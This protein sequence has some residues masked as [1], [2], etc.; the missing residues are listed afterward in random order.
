MSD[1]S[2]VPLSSQGKAE[3]VLQ[4]VE[5]MPAAKKAAYTKAQERCPQLMKTESDPLKFLR[6]DKDNY[7]KAAERLVMYWEERQALFG[8]KA[9]LPMTQTGNGALSVEDVMALHTG[10]YALL[11]KASSGEDVVFIDRN[12][13]LPTSTLEHKLRAFFYMLSYLTDGEHAQTLGCLVL[14]LLITPRT[15]KLDLA[16]IQSGIKLGNMMPLK[17]RMHLLMCHPKSGTTTFVQSVMTLGLSYASANID[18]IEVHSKPAGE[19]IMRSL[20][21]LGLVPADL[22]CSI[23]GT[24]KYESYTWW[25]R[26]RGTEEHGM[27]KVCNAA[28]ARANNTFETKRKRTQSLNVIHSRLKRERRKSE[29][30]ELQDAHNRLVGE[31]SQLVQERTRLESLLAQAREALRASEAARF[32]NSG[33]ANPARV[34]HF[35]GRHGP[36]EAGTLPTSHRDVMPSGAMGTAAH[37]HSP[38]LSSSLNVVLNQ[39]PELQRLLL[40]ALEEKTRLQQQLAQAAP[41]PHNPLL[42]DPRLQAAVSI[43]QYQAS[44]FS[45][46]ARLAREREAAT[47]D[48]LT[49]L[50]QSQRR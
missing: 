7:W 1:A 43:Q 18:G 42:H 10:N 30:Q 24:W 39:P 11:P 27:D 8:E 22:P 13:V 14:V 5:E 46:N 20:S 28:K 21:P 31:N 19:P 32:P 47:L 48:L 38:S 23:G 45:D 33:L 37:V 4:A 15:T 35:F 40:A 9:F 16:F 12:R 2:R 44:N 25:C 36:A 3:R 26:G 6:Y 50:A 41:A 17:A 29:Q 49:L 34:A